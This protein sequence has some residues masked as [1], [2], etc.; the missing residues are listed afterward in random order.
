MTYVEIAIDGVG[1][2]A[3]LLEE[4]AP[5]ATAALRA[6]LSFA[7]HAVHGQWDGDLFRTVES[8]ALPVPPRESGVGFQHPGLVVLDPASG[9]LAICYGQGRLNEHT[10]PLTPI[11]VAEIGGDLAPLAE[12]GRSLQWTGTRPFTM[13]VSADQEA[14]LA[15]P[16]SP[17]GR[18]IEVALGDTLTTATLL[19]ET[20]PQ[21]TA[22]FARLL[23]LSGRATNTISSGPLTRFWNANGGPEGET[24]LDDVSDDPGQVIL[25]PGYLYYLPARPWRGIRI[26]REATMMRGPAGGG[27]PHLVPLARFDGDWSAFADAAERLMQDGAQ[28]MSIRLR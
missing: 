2:R 13:A 22:A 11:P 1:F 15:P 10:I 27:G 24:P 19:E 4:R 12:A 18:T 8:I 26:A 14:P 17:V 20:S 3:R 21:T 9:Q 5:G 7:G 25:Y 6:A 16:P 28:P 23:P